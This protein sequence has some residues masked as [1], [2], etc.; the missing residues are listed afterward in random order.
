MTFTGPKRQKTEM[1][2]TILK[3]DDPDAFESSTY[4]HNFVISPT[5]K[6]D[7]WDTIDAYW[8]PCHHLLEGWRAFMREVVAQK[9]SQDA[10]VFQ[11]QDGDAH[12]DHVLNLIQA[13]IDNLPIQLPTVPVPISSATAK[14]EPQSP[15][16]ARAPIP[17]EPTKKVVRRSTRMTNVKA[18]A[19][20]ATE[21]PPRPKAQSKARPRHLSDPSTPTTPKESNPIPARVQPRRQVRDRT[22]SGPTIGKRA[23]E[24]HHPEAPQAKRKRSSKLRP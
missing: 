15:A 10:T 9:E 4:K 24:N 8:E 13:A 23:S 21:R 11:S 6:K 19:A 16:E 12:Y 18:A 7:V 2:R 14:P 17:T 3:W 20:V 1:P 5:I 22:A